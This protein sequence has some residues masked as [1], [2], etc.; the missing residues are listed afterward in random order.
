MKKV[1]F[2]L[3]V[4]ILMASAS[5]A[6]DSIYV[7][8]GNVGLGFDMGK[9]MEMGIEAGYASTSAPT[10]TINLLGRMQWELNKLS[11]STSTY[12]GG[13]LGLTS[14]TAAGA[15]TTTITLNVLA[16][17]EYKVSANLAIF[18]D[19]SLLLFRTASAGG[20]STTT[21]N[22]INGSAQVY[23]GGRIYL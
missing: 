10:S 23:T 8:G 5:F 13:T 14:A 2:T 11:K 16:G 3:L 21:L 17:A 19:I 1:L 9:G 22:L 20:A 7:S 6:V 18:G 15:T 12:M 4:V